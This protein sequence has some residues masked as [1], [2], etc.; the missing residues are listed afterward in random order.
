MRPTNVGDS[1]TPRFL[2]DGAGARFLSPNKICGDQFRE[3]RVGWRKSL[4]GEGTLV[5]RIFDSPP[6][7]PRE[8]AAARPRFR[9]RSKMAMPD[10]WRARLANPS[11][12]QE[13]PSHFY[14]ARRDRRNER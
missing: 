3:L 14:R 10:F 8:S 9:L 12:S 6:H 1:L 4:G 11:Y 5:G 13:C 7:T 2:T